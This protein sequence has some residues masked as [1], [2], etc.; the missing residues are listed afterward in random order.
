[1]RPPEKARIVVTKVTIGLGVTATIWV[2]SSV[3]FVALLL[4][5]ARRATPRLGQRAAEVPAWL[6]THAP[7]FKGDEAELTALRE[8]LRELRTIVDERVPAPV[9]R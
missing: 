9:D 6:R 4:V 5:G 3:A 7:E 2:V 8:E 1:M